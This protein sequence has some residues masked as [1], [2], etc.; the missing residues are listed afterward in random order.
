MSTDPLA[1][2]FYL[3]KEIEHLNLMIWNTNTDGNV[4]YPHL[5]EV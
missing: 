2:L 5:D 1:L 3:K 4:A